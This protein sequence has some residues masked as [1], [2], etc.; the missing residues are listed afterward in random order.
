MRC[1][2]VFMYWPCMEHVSMT[3]TILDPSPFGHQPGG[4]STFLSPAARLLCHPPALRRSPAFLTL[5][6]SSTSRVP[7]RGMA[8]AHTARATRPGG[9]KSTFLPR[10]PGARDQFCPRA[11][12]S[13]RIPANCLK[14]VNNTLAEFLSGFRRVA[15]YWRQ[16]TPWPAN[17]RA[18][19]ESIS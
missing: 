15:K 11:Q 9:R 18:E 19:R 4:G 17:N 13:A 7:P 10:P 1:M 6:H 16:L 5:L 12:P 2:Y 8:R 3:C 14:V